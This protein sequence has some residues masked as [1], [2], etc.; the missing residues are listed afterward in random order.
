MECLN[1]VVELI[2]YENIVEIALHIFS[3]GTLFGWIVDIIPMVI[4]VYTYI[5]YVKREHLDDEQKL[6]IILIFGACLQ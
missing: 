2:R 6:Y 3:T 1:L 5:K 4:K